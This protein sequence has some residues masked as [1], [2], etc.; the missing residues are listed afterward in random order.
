MQGI[1][2]SSTIL[3]VED[4]EDFRS[5]LTDFLESKSFKV[6]PADSAEQAMGKLLLNKIDKVIT[7]IQIPE[8]VQGIWLIMQIKKQFPTLP[9]IAMS[10]GSV[11]VEEEDYFQ[12]IN[13]INVENIFKKPFHPKEILS[14][15]IDEEEQD[16]SNR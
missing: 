14:A 2:V 5:C 12:L 8:Y 10:G 13:L 1:T 7:D 15:I 6:L 11:H 3:L 16:I 4:D 9:V